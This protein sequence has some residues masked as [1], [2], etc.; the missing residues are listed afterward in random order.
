MTRSSERI[1]A[2]E[3]GIRLV[4]SLDQLLA[5]ADVVSL[6][7]PLTSETEHLINAEHIAK[8]KPGAILINT[9][10]ADWSITTRCSAH[11]TTADCS[12]PASM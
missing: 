5:E 9:A 6:H 8:M 2:A 10:G 3:S 1:D 12:V 7:L 4:D 11:S